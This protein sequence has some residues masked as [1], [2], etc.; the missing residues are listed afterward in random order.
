MTIT[1][2]GSSTQTFRVAQDAGPF[3]RLVYACAFQHNR[4]AGFSESTERHPRWLVHPYL[5]A[6]GRRLFEE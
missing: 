6:R 1:N 3:T 5:L 2:L 4:H